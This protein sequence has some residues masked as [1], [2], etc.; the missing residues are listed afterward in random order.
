MQLTVKQARKM[1]G[2][3]QQAMAD[4]LGIN[5]STYIKLE[6]NPDEITVGQAKKICE[7]T[8]VVIDNIFFA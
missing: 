2:L 1:A 4:G 3:T 8:G 6:K 7:M 5:R